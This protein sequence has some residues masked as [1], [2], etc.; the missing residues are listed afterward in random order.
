VTSQ[1]CFTAAAACAETHVDRTRR[2]RTGAS[3]G[4][5]AGSFRRLCVGSALWTDDRDDGMGLAKRFCKPGPSNGSD[6]ALL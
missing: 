1:R 6:E 5:M 2:Q 4:T 3:L